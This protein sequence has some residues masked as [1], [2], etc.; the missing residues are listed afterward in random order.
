MSGPA[1]LA[2]DEREYSIAQLEGLSNG[3]ATTLE[4]RGVRAGDRVALMSSN[5]PEFVV[6]LRANPGDR[7]VAA[8]LAHLLELTGRDLELLALLSARIDESP[9]E[10]RD[11]LVVER[12]RILGVL[13]AKARAEGRA[14]EADLYESMRGS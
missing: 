4:Q 3:M 9:D 8:R 10:E 5:R 2:F 1:A 11:E 12:D 14:S 7:A 6:A 13:A